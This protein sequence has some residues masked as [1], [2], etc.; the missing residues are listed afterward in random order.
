MNANSRGPWL[1]FAVLSLGSFMIVL[2]HKPRGKL[3]RWWSESD[4][5][6]LLGRVAC[7]ILVA[8]AAEE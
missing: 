1:A 8:T 4:E 7:S 6:S 5:E 3:A 2:G